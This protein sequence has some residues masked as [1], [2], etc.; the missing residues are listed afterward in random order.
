[1]SK[2]TIMA[3][4]GDDMGVHGVIWPFALYRF[5]A[6]PLRLF[7]YDEIHRSVESEFPNV[8][9]TMFLIIILMFTCC[10]SLS[11]SPEIN[12]WILTQ[13]D[14]VWCS[15]FADNYFRSHWQ[16]MFWIISHFLARFIEDTTPSLS[17]CFVIKIVPKSFCEYSCFATIV[18]QIGEGQRW[19]VMHSHGMIMCT[20]SGIWT[21]SADSAFPMNIHYAQCIMFWFTDYSHC[22]D[23]MT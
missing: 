18:A 2:C 1:M 7:L 3:Q 4:F 19:D 13:T 20:L 10:F 15:Q 12:K 23:I 8:D 14:C 21:L 11:V 9:K 17:W 16:R 5:V 22:V 6:N